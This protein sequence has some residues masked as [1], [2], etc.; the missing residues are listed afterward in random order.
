MVFS[1]YL[2]LFG[3]ILAEI[4]GTAA[5]KYSDGMTRLKPALV[6]VVAYT[7]AFWLAALSL[8]VLPLSIAGAIWEGLCIVGLTLIGVLLFDEKLSRVEITGMAMILSGTVLLTILSA[9]TQHV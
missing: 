6:V 3:A 9:A 1:A 5:L 4:V 2:L 8:R 7:V